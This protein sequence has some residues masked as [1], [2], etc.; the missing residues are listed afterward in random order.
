[1]QHATARLVSGTFLACLLATLMVHAQKTVK[2]NSTVDYTLTVE[3]QKD[4][5]IA[6]WW[7]PFVKDNTVEGYC[8]DLNTLPLVNRPQL[9]DKA[10]ILR[11]GGAGQLT[12]VIEIAP[13]QKTVWH[14][15]GFEGEA[16]FYVLSGRGQTEYKGMVGGLPSNKY[17]WKKN[18]L[19]AIP[20]DHEMQ[21]TNLDPKESVRLLAV[22]G[23][24]I[25]MYPYVEESLRSGRQNPAEGPVERAATL[26]RTTYPGHFVDD[27][28]EHPV[29]M[30]EARGNKTAF[31]N[32]MS[33]VGHRTHPN[34][35]ISELTGT[36]AFAHKHGNQPMFVILKGDGYDL[37]SEAPDLKAFEAAVASKSA[38]RAEY[39]PGTLCG[40]PGGPHW[41]QHFSTGPD[42]LRYLA[43]VPRGQYEEKPAATGGDAQ[44]AAPAVQQ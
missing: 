3:K 7:Q 43:I 27:L 24:A 31:F 34:I 32:L 26:A 10:K 41:H 25:N 17:T 4:A 28:R 39:H 44:P 21:H 22:T 18:S 42:P 6:S 2:F 35:H 30:R 20:V 9:G 5:E 19:F 1:M 12:Q 37:W 13:G 14:G 16:M 23:Y 8:W 29:A 15:Y 33:V 36:Q 11:V 40:V 38:H